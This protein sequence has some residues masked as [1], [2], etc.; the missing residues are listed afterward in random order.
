MGHRHFIIHKPEPASLLDATNAVVDYLK[1]KS[2]TIDALINLDTGA[3]DTFRFYM[4]NGDVSNKLRG[5]LELSDAR[6]LV[7]YYYE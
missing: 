6:N 3:Q 2:Y 4:D 1:S 5:R 7:V